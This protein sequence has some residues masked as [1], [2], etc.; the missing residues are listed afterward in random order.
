M[1]DAKHLHFV[2]AQKQAG[3]IQHYIHV[4]TCTCRLSTG[5]KSNLNVVAL[6]IEKKTTEKSKYKQ[7]KAVLKFN[8]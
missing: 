5:V 2:Q 1:H 8:M 7:R 3:H 6:S 4:C